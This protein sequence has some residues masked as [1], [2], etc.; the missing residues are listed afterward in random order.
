MS[1]TWAATLSL[2][3]CRLI[4]QA[5]VDAALRRPECDRIGWTMDIRAQSTPQ[6]RSL[7]RGAQAGEAAAHDQQPVPMMH[8][9]VSSALHDIAA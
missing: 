4:A 9:Q 5:G 2:C 3:A 7:D 8:A 6:P 1:N